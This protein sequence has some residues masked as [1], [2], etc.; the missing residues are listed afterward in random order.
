MDE[1][2]EIT[3]YIQE[4]TKNSAEVIWGNGIDESLEDNISVTIIATGFDE[5][6]KKKPAERKAGDRNPPLRAGNKNQTP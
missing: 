3:D 4:K 6:H 2:S 5:E 1:V